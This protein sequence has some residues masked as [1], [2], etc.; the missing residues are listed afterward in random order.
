MNLVKSI[1]DTWTIL[2]YPYDMNSYAEAQAIETEVKR[3]EA[4]G[5][6]VCVLVKSYADSEIM[7]ILN[8][9]YTRTTKPSTYGEICVKR[10]Q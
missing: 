5:E 9:G 10:K 8:K 4:K 1:D 3:L 2:T 7:G 6:E